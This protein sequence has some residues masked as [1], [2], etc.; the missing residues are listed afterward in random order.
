MPECIVVGAGLIGMLTARELR[1]AGLDVVLYE[2]GAAGQES[3]WAG[4]GILSPLYPWRYDRAVSNLARWSQLHYPTLAQ[5][6]LQATGI[7]PEWTASGLLILDDH[8]AVERARAWSQQYQQALECVEPERVRKIEANIT[9]ASGPAF[10]LPNIAQIR[11]PR[12]VK[13]VKQDV[14]QSGVVLHE[15]TPVL[16]MVTHKNRAIGIQTAAGKVLSDQVVVAGGAWSGQLLADLGAKL[17]V[18]PVRG[19][20]LM[21]STTPGTVRRIVL[22]QDHYVIPRRDGRVLVGSTLEHVGFEKITTTAALQELQTFACALVPSLRNFPI[23]RHW[24][25]LRP[26]S[27]KGI[28]YI[29]EHPIIHKLYINAG[30]YRN[31]VVLAAA[32]ARLLAD[33]VLARASILNGKDYTLIPGS[34]GNVS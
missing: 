15:H 6:L 2:R 22:T 13:A 33:I 24:A 31:G 32:S 23:E 20:M 16:S 25:G 1:Q 18:K 5:Q 19:Q 30:H 17:Q 7:D 8:E 27:P 4:G 9:P 10:W 29:S 14:L 3:S 28:P 12:L 11:N 21:F 26:G 34:G